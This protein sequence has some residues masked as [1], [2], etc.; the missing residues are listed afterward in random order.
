MH[1]HIYPVWFDGEKT[2]MAVYG[3]DPHKLTRS[4]AHKS[5]ESIFGHVVI[6]PL[7][8]HENTP[9]EVLTPD[10]GSTS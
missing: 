8:R 4:G 6:Y 1:R 9:L 3:D 2:F 10:N 5:A 7:D